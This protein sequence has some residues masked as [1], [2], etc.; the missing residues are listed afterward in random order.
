[1]T[2]NSELILVMY[3][4]VMP[5]CRQGYHN[6]LLYADDLCDSHQGNG[7]MV[8]LFA[9]IQNYLVSYPALKIA[10]NCKLNMQHHLYADDT[11]L[12][13]TFPPSGHTRAFERME[14]CVREVK[15]WL[16]DNDSS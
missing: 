2:V 16:C 1:M 12:Y 5:V 13:V 9:D 15:T 10:L 7:T 3:I 8:C 11:Q 6:Y 4:L 14:A